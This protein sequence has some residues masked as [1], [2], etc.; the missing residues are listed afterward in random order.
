MSAAPEPP[1]GLTRYASH[2]G[3][4]RSRLL[5]VLILFLLVFLI[6]FAS[7][8]PLLQTAQWPLRE[9]GRPAGAR[10]TAAGVE[11]VAVHP[12]DG[13]SALALC[14]LALAVL[15]TTPY[16]VWQ[17]WRFAAPGLTGG[18]ARILGRSLLGGLA[19]FY[20]GGGLGYGVAAP[21]AFH[22]LLAWNR[23]LGVA[24]LWTAPNVAGFTLGISAGFALAA[25]VPLVLAALGRLGLVHAAALRRARRAVVLG[26][27]AGAAVLT[28]PD[29]LTQILLAGILIALYEA[30][31]LL[32]AAA[33]HRAAAAQDEV[34]A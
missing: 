23:W 26:A 20:A 19:L 4:L 11:A 8:R 33:Q 31:V 30:G 10:Q 21:L 28:P 2:I 9:A 1:A 18:E 3:E 7:G 32:V 17:G 13:L 6:G 12:L 5:R 24:N 16:A 22:Y 15:V 34:V 14:A 29:P 27:L 25:E